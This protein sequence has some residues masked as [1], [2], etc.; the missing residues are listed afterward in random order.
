MTRMLVTQD[1]VAADSSKQV[2]EKPLS[3]ATPMKHFVRNT[4]CEDGRYPQAEGPPYDTQESR[5]SHCHV[6]THHSKCCDE[7]DDVEGAECIQPL[8]DALGPLASGPLRNYAKNVAQQRE[9]QQDVPIT[10]KGVFSVAE[11]VSSRGAI[12]ML[13]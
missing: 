4:G 9:H 5:S 7:C 13:A 11:M 2:A 10:R 3:L 6:R 8:S 1:G 12:R